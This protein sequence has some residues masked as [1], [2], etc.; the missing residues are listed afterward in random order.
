MVMTAERLQED[1]KTNGRESTWV[2][3]KEAACME[4]DRLYNNEIS[5]DLSVDELVGV[6][7]SHMLR[8]SIFETQLSPPWCYVYV[9]GLYG[10]VDNIVKGTNNSNSA[11]TINSKEGQGVGLDYEAVFFSLNRGSVIGAPNVRN[12]GGKSRGRKDK[13]NIQRIMEVEGELDK[14]SSGLSISNH[15]IRN[16][17]SILR[18]A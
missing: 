2:D 7:V 14:I 1:G 8:R 5:L 12:G 13:R 9:D 18:R 11:A 15:D 3:I 16:R 17:N 10:D 4:C 6:P